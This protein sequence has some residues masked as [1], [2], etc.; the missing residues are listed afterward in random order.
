M[1]HAHG[2]KKTAEEKRAEKENAKRLL[3]ETNLERVFHILAGYATKRSMGETL[4][5]LKNRLKQLRA[6][7]GSERGVVYGHVGPVLTQEEVKMEVERLESRESRTK[8]QL[9]QLE[10]T[11]VWISSEDVVEMFKKLGF[12]GPLDRP[13]WNMDKAI[14]RMIFECDESMT[15]SL[16]LE[17][18]KKA[19]YRCINDDTGLE[20]FDFFNLVRFFF[21]VALLFIFYFS[22]STGLPLTSTHFHSLLIFWFSCLC[23]KTFRFN[24]SCMTRIWVVHVA[25]MKL[26]L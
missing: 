16:T 6:Q 20:P 25:L 9:K 7:L 19:Y 8:S 4:D 5:D 13:D 14:D 23:C 24:F 17:D 26:E 18:M 22:T 15:N 11:I 10:K 1:S 21:C 12:T 2:E 3:L